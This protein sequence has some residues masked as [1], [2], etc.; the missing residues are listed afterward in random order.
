MQRCRRRRVR[1]EMIPGVLTH[2]VRQRRKGFWRG[3][4]TAVA[5]AFSVAGADTRSRCD[6]GAGYQP[7]DGLHAC[8]P[9]VG[10]PCTIE[11]ALHGDNGRALG[12]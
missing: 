2:D 6:F 11:L 3:V 5:Q 12:R 7:E 8:A 10:G 1:A 4:S 9:G